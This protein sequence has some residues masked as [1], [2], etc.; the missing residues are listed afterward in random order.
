[1]KA[2]SIKLL[3]FLIVNYLVDSI[4]LKDKFYVT[5]LSAQEARSLFICK[6]VNSQEVNIIPPMNKDLLIVIDIG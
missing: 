5:K 3:L 2:L 6:V 4:S 1:M